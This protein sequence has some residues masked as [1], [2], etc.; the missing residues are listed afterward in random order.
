M[1]LANLLANRYKSKDKKKKKSCRGGTASSSSIPE[2]YDNHLNEDGYEDEINIP[3]PTVKEPA[4]WKRIDGSIK[5]ERTII[6]AGLQTAEEFEQQEES[7]HDDNNN[8]NKT[9]EKEIKPLIEEETVYRDSTGRRIDIKS[10]VNS[11][12]EKQ[13]NETIEKERR[14]KEI[15][16]G[17]VQRERKRK[18]REDEELMKNESYT[19]REDDIRRNEELKNQE[20]FNDPAASF[21]SSKKKRKSR[22]AKDKDGHRDK[23]P[24]SSK[25]EKDVYKGPYPPNRFNIPPGPNWDGV[26]RS[27]GFEI[28]WF[29]AQSMKKEQKDFKYAM[30]VDY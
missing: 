1:S 21:L 17:Q 28:K 16:M 4:S 14:I 20:L 6:K 24:S 25:E 10:E 22:H 26:D 12:A 7:S 15:N 2:S 18:Q 29:K 13:R 30:Q 19:V 8:N 11:A 3:D 27:N 23:R 5:T 9:K